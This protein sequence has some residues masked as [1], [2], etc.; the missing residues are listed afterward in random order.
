[1]KSEWIIR[2]GRDVK[3]IPAV[4]RIH[5]AGIHP[6]GIPSTFVE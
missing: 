4:E 6:P 5:A 2:Y 3:R 1:M